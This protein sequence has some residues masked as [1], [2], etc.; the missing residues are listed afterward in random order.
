MPATSA[1]AAGE[2]GRRANIAPRPDPSC[3]GR[4]MVGSIDPRCGTL[5]GIHWP[6]QVAGLFG[7]RVAETILASGPARPHQKAGHMDAS[8]PI[9]PLRTLAARGPSTY[10]FRSCAKWRI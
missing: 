8:D 2:I 3:Q 7:I 1:T 9:R 10:G 4:Q 6:K 5:R